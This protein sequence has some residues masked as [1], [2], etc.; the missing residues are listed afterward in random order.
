MVSWK[1]LSE[2]EKAQYAAEAEKR[3]LEYEEIL[4]AYTKKQAEGPATEGRRKTAKGKKPIDPSIQKAAAGYLIFV[5][6]YR[7]ENPDDTKSLSI[8]S[9]PMVSW[10]QLSEAEKAQY[11]AKAEKR[12]FEYEEILSAYTKKQAEVHMKNLNLRCMDGSDEAC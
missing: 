6:K 4:S 9:K 7:K 12:K 3:K 10:K 8:V 11:A 2:A 5:E 1:Q